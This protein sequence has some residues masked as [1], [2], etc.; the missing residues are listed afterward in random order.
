MGILK[1]LELAWNAGEQKV[2]LEMDS[3]A[4]LDLIQ[5]AGPD[6]PL[7]NL[8]RHIR[9]Y[10]CKDWVCKLQYVWREGN[11]CADWLAKQSVSSD[12]G[13]R[14]LTEPLQELRE[15]IGADILGVATPRFVTV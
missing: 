3:K 4:A 5:G 8:I 2:I 6:S 14:I 13:M 11:K 12:P 7:S 15:L 9:D 10:T 1:G